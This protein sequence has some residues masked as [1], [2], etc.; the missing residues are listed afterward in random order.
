MARKKSSK[1]A[2]TKRASGGVQKQTKGRNPPKVT[3]SDDHFELPVKGH[4]FA[5]V[6]YTK[7]RD[8]ASGQLNPTAGLPTPL[9]SSQPESSRRRG[10][11]GVIVYAPNIS[12]SSC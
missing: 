2:T 7:T 1:K 3:A 10:M 5:V 6:I 9:K 4:N 12:H 11:W 8:K